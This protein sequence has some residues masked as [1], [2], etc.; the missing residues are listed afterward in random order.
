MGEF[1]S[2]PPDAE[3]LY[4]SVSSMGHYSLD[5]AIA[6]I[7]DNS[8]TAKAKNINILCE[9]NNGKNPY[10]KIIDDGIGMDLNELLLA[11]KLGSK[12]PNHDRD[13]KDLGRF[14]LG[15]KT[16]SFSQGKILTVISSK[17]GKEVNGI[18]I[19][20]DDVKN[21]K[22]EKLYK[23]EIFK[24]LSVSD[25]KNSFTEV[26]WNKL[27]RIYN[28][29]KKVIPKD[30]FN[31][32][33]TQAKR[34]LELTFHRYLESN[35]TN[36]KIVIKI[37]N[38]NLVA[39]D[40]FIKG[41]SEQWA[42]EKIKIFNREIRMQTYI[43]PHYS[44]LDNETIKKLSG[45]E[46]YVRNQGFYVYRN[47]RLIFKG[48]WFKLA[49]H[50]DLS[51]LARVQL[52]IPNDIDEQFKITID[53]SYAELPP[54]LRDRMKGLVERIQG[55]STRVFRH[56]GAKVNNNKDVQFWARKVKEKR[57]LYSINTKHPFILSFEKLIDKKAKGLFTNIIK[58]IEY[59]LPADAI[60][61]DIKDQ[62][63]KIILGNTSRDFVVETI[64]NFIN[65][66]LQN[67]TDKRKILETLKTTS[68]YK[69]NTKIIDEI[70]REKEFI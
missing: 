39:N 52:D 46:G 13:K 61:I 48:T 40:P 26:H 37:N 58:H 47:K 2:N 23:D 68:F 67:N 6:D 53:K 14:G 1:I 24:I 63:D 5:A 21:W 34:D 30:S 11:T 54:G 56:I 7:I 50:G 31:E 49:K 22:V 27:H 59:N 42:L 57:I 69:A 9:W 55:K 45:K 33:I 62:P 36:N 44:D 29:K 15:L 65:F 4:S 66:N 10:I 43:L 16:A 28:E 32:L 35:N 64:E 70:L 8:I 17:D 60:S 41:T 12:N 38:D 3:N 25:I 20:I 51:K 18:K 19:N